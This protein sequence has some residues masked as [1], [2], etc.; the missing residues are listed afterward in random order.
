MFFELFMDF[1]I[2][3][4]HD[5]S[6][7]KRE[8][9]TRP[10]RGYCYICPEKY[11][12]NQ[13]FSVKNASNVLVNLIELHHLFVKIV[14]INCFYIFMPFSLLDHNGPRYVCA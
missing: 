11:Q 3:K 6:H 5:V 9:S 12:K 1:S 2:K 10:A 8:N 14:K 7:S 13:G 4:M